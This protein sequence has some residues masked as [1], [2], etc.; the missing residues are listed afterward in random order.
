MNDIIIISKLSLIKN[1]RTWS[2]SKINYSSGMTS[3]ASQWYW[4]SKIYRSNN[5]FIWGMLITLHCLSR[6]SVKTK[7]SLIKFKSKDI[8]LV[9]NKFQPSPL[10]T[11]LWIKCKTQR[12]ENPTK[13]SSQEV[14]YR[15]VCRGQTFLDI[16]LEL[17][18]TSSSSTMYKL[19]MSR[20]TIQKKNNITPSL[21]KAGELSMRRL[22]TLM[23]AGR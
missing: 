9:K 15:L 8:E 17:T 14:S 20:V 22:D 7:N 11:K 10:E 3:L 2:E 5:S 21:L 23:M 12:W 19:T 13:Y 18:K 4:I 1:L 16:H 6:H